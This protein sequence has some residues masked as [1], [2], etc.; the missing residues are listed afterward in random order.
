MAKII[1]ACLSVSYCYTIS[2][3]PAQVYN[4]SIRLILKKN[5]SQKPEVINAELANI[6]PKA[7]EFYNKALELSKERDHKGAIEQLELAIKEFPGF[8]IG[9]NEIGYQY[10]L[11]TEY[12]KAAQAFQSALKIKP[13][14]ILPLTN[15][16]IVLTCQNK[17]KEAEVELRKVIKLEEK[18][19]VAHYYLAY[20]IANQSKFD[21]VQKKFLNNRFDEAEKEFL[22]AVKYGGDSMKEA[23]RYLAVIYSSKGDKKHQIAELETYLQLA[24]NAAD[25]EQL[26]SLVKK[27][28]E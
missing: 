3:I 11:L 1:R 2:G 5:E 18:S 17:F 20:S 13:D 23:H 22:N 19:A 25:A 21:E 27:L 4:V 9:Y 14:A 28:K 16:G 12:E 10:L 15:Y 26:R 6:P 8:I 7:V 24:P